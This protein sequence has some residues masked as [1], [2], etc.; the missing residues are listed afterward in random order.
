MGRVLLG[1]LP[2][3][4]LDEYFARAKLEK[5]TART[6]VDRKKMQAQ[7]AKDK[8]QGWSFVDQEHAAGLCSVAA[9]VFNAAGLAFA[10]L[11]VGWLAGTE[12]PS[13]T[14]DRVVPKL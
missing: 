14:R 1:G 5:L 3:R 12:S 6:L 4:E 9:P 10:A 8:V 7:I 11:G 2:P 13:A